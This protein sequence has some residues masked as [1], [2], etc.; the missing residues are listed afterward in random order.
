MRNEYL[1][2]VRATQ[3]CGLLDSVRASRQR[4]SFFHVSQTIMGTTL[5]HQQA[6]GLDM[7]GCGMKDDDE[8]EDMIFSFVFIAVTILTMLF[9]VAGVVSL[10]WSFI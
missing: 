3:A 10:V 2:I 1:Q 4:P 5:V 7:G 9:A 6:A 8:N